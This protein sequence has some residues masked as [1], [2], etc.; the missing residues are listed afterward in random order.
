MLIDDI[1]SLLAAPKPAAAE[2][3]L[4]RVDATLTDGYAHA[5]Q[6]E[7]ERWRIERRIDQVVAALPAET[8]EAE[9]P[10]LAELAERLTA[11]NENIAALRTLL[12]S[13]RARRSEIRAAA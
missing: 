12:T 3:F 7:A 11:A 4:D 13:L 6:L 10:E 8:V 5:L 2:P 1:H 9:T